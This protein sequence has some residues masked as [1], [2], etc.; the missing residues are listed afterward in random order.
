MACGLPSSTVRLVLSSSTPCWAQPTRLPPGWGKAGNGVP[1]SRCISLKMFCS[2]GG[3]RTP[4]DRECQPLGLPAAVIGSCPRIT[5]RTSC[6]AVSSSA[7]RGLGKD[8]RTGIQ[9]LLQELQ[10]L[11]AGISRKR[12][13]Q[14]FANLTRLASPADLHSS[15]G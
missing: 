11:L 8:H 10:Q 6:D 12:C 13:R 5:T 9:P 3:T 1:S 15:T 2:E 14:R 4:G 7:L